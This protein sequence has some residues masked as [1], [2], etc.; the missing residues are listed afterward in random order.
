MIGEATV[1]SRGRDGHDDGQGSATARIMAEPR[2]TDEVVVLVA[3]DDPDMAEL[4]CQTLGYHGFLVVIAEDGEKALA[5]AEEIAPHAICL[6]V[7]MPRLDGLQVLDR[8]RSGPR[9]AAIPAIMVTNYDEPEMMEQAGRLGA[10]RF[11]VKLQIRPAEL[12]GVIREVLALPERRRPGR[13]PMSLGAHPATEAEQMITAYRD[14]LQTTNTVLA[15]LSE[16]AEEQRRQLSG[17]AAQF[18]AQ[19]AYWHS[20]MQRADEI[21]QRAQGDVSR[22]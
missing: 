7:R 1:S 21:T 22:N 8:L 10:V 19:L 11:L 5:L 4:Y 2:P 18:R 13:L 9:T 12:A 3:E 6:D 17:Y 14:L 20:V 15:E 16:G